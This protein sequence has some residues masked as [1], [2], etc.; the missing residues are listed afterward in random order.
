MIHASWDEY[1]ENTEMNTDKAAG[2]DDLAGIFFT[3]GA[4]V[5]SKPITDLINLSITLS[6]V[7][8]SSK[9]AKLK[10]L[11][12]KGSKLE[13]KIFRPISLLSLISKVLERVIHDQTQS[14][15]SK[16][17]ILY[18]YQS[19]FRK[20]H[21][22]DTCLKFLNNKI[23]K[24]ID[25]GLMTGLILIDLQKDFDTIDH[26]IL[27]NKMTHMGFSMQSI[28]WF[29]SYITNRTFLVNVEKT[30]SDPGKLVGLLKVQ[31]WALSCSLC[32]LMICLGLS[33]VKYYC[34]QMILAWSCKVNTSKIL[35]QYWIQ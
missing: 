34:M 22:T 29:S 13:P 18:N 5:L 6:S 10:P 31:S 3:D 12:K 9:I 20:Y 14:Y 8:D 17:N 35:H 32:M 25:E 2:I 33:T 19:G 21:S 30:F 15:L 7:P 23:L 4:K 26:K 11:L 28:T 27:L 1:W 16:N 24:G